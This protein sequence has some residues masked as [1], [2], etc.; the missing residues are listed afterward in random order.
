MAGTMS[1]RSLTIF[2]MGMVTMLVATVVVMN[3]WRV[4]AA[5]GDEDTTFVP[6]TPCRLADTRPDTTV[7]P[8]NTPI[9]PGE[10]LLVQA[11]GENGNCDLP[12]DATGLSLNVTATDATLPTFLTLWGEGERP[13]ASSLNPVPGAVATPN[14]VTTPLSATGSFN[15]FN[16][17]GTV[18]VI[19]D[20]NGYHTKASLQEL[21]AQIAL[22]EENVIKLN[23]KHAS[24]PLV[25]TSFEGTFQ[26]LT[27]TPTSYVSV[28]ILALSDGKV[29]L[30]ST[31]RVGHTLAAGGTVQCAIVDAAAIPAVL[32][33]VPSLQVF[34]RAANLTGGSQS[35]LSGNRTF[36]ISAGSQVTYGLACEEINNNG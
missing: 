16:L 35:S 31:A 21:S 9:N 18:N 14:G 13:D 17:Q 1:T 15:V 26:D 7:G 6:I 2:A 34:D 32:L 27:G 28:T 29:A 25:E 4:D 33:G 3:T 10:E 12:T 36:D 5:P 19:V 30:N 8:R 20:V 23:G 11:T 24:G 22:L